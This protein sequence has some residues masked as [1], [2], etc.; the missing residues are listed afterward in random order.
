MSYSALLID[1]IESAGTRTDARPGIIE[2]IIGYLNEVF[3]RGLFTTQIQNMALYA[4]H[5]TKQR[6]MRNYAFLSKYCS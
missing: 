3:R 5:N 4:K 2:R 6:K 1:V